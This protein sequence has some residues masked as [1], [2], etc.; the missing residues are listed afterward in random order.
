MIGG[1]AQMGSKRNIAFCMI[2]LVVF[3]TSCSPALPTFRIF[4]HPE[5]ATPIVSNKDTVFRELFPFKEVNTYIVFWPDME[6]LNKRDCI[7]LSLENVSEKR[8]IFPSDY[9]VKVFT[10]VNESDWIE[11]ENSAHY[12]PPGNPQ[13]SPKGPDSPG[14]IG[15]PLCPE[16]TDFELPIGIRV[17]VLG[18]TEAVQ[19]EA[20]EQ[21][22]AYIDVVIER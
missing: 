4:E 10:Y 6:I 8:V 11:I 15:V 21:V 7:E 12:F 19:G 22:G 13:V 1:E 17:V 20:S 5:T 9:G 14:V 3:T 18:Q 2:L 16:L